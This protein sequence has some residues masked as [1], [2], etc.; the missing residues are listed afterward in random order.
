MSEKLQDAAA[1]AAAEGS[2][3]DSIIDNTHLARTET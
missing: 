2:L 3:L 1:S